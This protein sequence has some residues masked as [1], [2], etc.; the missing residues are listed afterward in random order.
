MLLGSGELLFCAFDLGTRL[1]EGPLEIVDDVKFLDWKHFADFGFEILFEGEGEFWLTA[2]ASGFALDVFQLLDVLERDEVEHFYAVT[3]TE[4]SSPWYFGASFSNPT[5]KAFASSSIPQPDKY[6]SSG[7]A[8]YF[9]H[10]HPGKGRE[11]RLATRFRVALT[12]LN[13][14]LEF[15]QQLT[16]NPNGF[17]PHVTSFNERLGLKVMRF[18]GTKKESR[19]NAL[20]NDW[21][22]KLIIFTTYL[23]HE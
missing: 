12:P 16:F 22:G 9:G 19:A 11:F 15:L 3:T 7:H 14:L 10:A 5:R 2:R 8:L 13:L 18:S 4:S 1:A 21:L 23:Y 6:L 20:E 17:V